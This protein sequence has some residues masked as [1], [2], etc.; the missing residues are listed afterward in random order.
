[1]KLL[2]PFL[3]LSVN[4]WAAGGGH[5]EVPVN[6]IIFQTINITILFAGLIYFTRKTVVDYFAQKKLAYIDSANRA[7]QAKADAEKQKVEVE[8]KLTHLE[9]TAGESVLRA[10]AEAA[11]MKKQMI[12][13]AQAISARIKQEAEEAVKMEVARAKQSLRQALLVDSMA[14]AK[15]KMSSGVSGEDHSR[16]QQNFLVNI[17]EA[18]Q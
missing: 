8:S 5:G 4:A 7:Q 3:L 2:I 18:K 1:M 9:Q 14:D 10:K 12:Q 15:S 17:K 16:L 11:D 13:D 6:T